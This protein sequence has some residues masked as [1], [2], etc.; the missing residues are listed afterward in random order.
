M[1]VFLGEE[2]MSIEDTT[3]LS[4]ELGSLVYENAIMAMQLDEVMCRA[5]MTQCLGT[6]SINKADLT[7]EELGTLL[8]HIDSGLKSFLEPDE[9][10]EAMRRIRHMILNWD[11]L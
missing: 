11:D 6:V 8:P 5:L 3:R 2:R 4:K 7:I 9:A 10:R 1:L